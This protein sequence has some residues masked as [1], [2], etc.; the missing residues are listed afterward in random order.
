[1]G[2]GAKRI[3]ATHPGPDKPLLVQKPMSRQRKIPL[4]EYGGTRDAEQPTLK[5]AHSQGLQATGGDLHCVR[6][7]TT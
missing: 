3:S 1:M 7:N 2:Q 6:S 5:R 4:S